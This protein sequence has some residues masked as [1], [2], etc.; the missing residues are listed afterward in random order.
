MSENMLVQGIRIGLVCGLVVSL[1][2]V[3]TRSLR[4]ADLDADD[5]RRA[6]IYEE[7]FEATFPPKGWRR[8]G[9]V[10]ENITQFDGEPKNGR[11]VARFQGSPLADMEKWNC[12]IR[13]EV[14]TAGFRDIEVSFALGAKLDHASEIFRATVSH[15]GW[16]GKGTWHDLHVL[17]GEDPEC[18]G[19]LRTYKVA[20]PEACNDKA[21]FVILFTLYAADSS[22]DSGYV[23]DV[24]ITGE[25]ADGKRVTLFSDDFETGLSKEWI[26]YSTIGLPDHAAIDDGDPKHG[27]QVV[28]FQGSPVTNEGDFD[29]YF[30]R[31]ISTEGYDDIEISFSMGTSGLDVPTKTFSFIW[32][33]MGF[34]EKPFHTAKKLE[35][36]DP[37]SDGKLQRFTISLP[38]EAADN[39]KFMAGFYLCGT[40][41][42]EDLGFLDDIVITGKRKAGK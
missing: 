38:K 20:A 11:Y 19:T 40:N 4:A 42:A 16:Y 1:P 15:A 33:E 14:S 3:S 27:R 13:K 31:I 9:T 35:G 8:M 34:Y 29:C 12:S 5:A 21:N 25:N 10:K 6:V 28:R 39:P 23:D 37:E 32:A 18:D 2:D 41:R 7:G 30:E 24:V 22:D 17:K 36:G 26:K